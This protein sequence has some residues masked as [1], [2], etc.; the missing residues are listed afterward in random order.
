MNVMERIFGPE[1]IVVV[2]AKS[3]TITSKTICRKREVA[4]CISEVMQLSNERLNVTIEPY[5]TK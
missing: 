2:Y 4:R 5:E 1:R 3:D